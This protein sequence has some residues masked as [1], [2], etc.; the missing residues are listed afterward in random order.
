VTWADPPRG[1]K[2]S[3][4]TTLPR[5]VDQLPPPARW[6]LHP[7]SPAP[8]TGRFSSNSPTRRGRGVA[9]RDQGRGDAG[10]VRCGRDRW[11]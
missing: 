9:G 3:A 7:E 2:K 8:C 1:K 11:L 5:V 4:E 10:R 6:W